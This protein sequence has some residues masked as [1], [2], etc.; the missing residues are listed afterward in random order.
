MNDRF[1]DTLTEAYAR[2]GASVAPPEDAAER[3][4]ARRRQLRTRRRMSTA[5]AGLAVVAVVGGGAVLAP[6]LVSSESSPDDTSSPAPAAPAPQ[7]QKA[8]DANDD[9]SRVKVADC[10]I[11]D[12][13]PIGP[14]QLKRLITD[15]Q[16][17]QVRSGR[18]GGK[19]F[20]AIIRSSPDATLRRKGAKTIYI[21]VDQSGPKAKISAYVC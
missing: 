16:L 8:P 7:R 4:T 19:S 5:A 3:V 21:E 17:R 6:G 14:T 18:G 10:K 13:R 11:A 12:R 20:G 2:L 15:A 9:L 1:D